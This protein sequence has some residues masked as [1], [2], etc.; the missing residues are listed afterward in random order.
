VNLI[1]N[2][3][4]RVPLW[5]KVQT[6]NR[7]GWRNAAKRLYVQRRILAT[8]SIETS[9]EGPVEVRMLTWHRDW[10]NCLWALKSFYCF[11][12]VQYP[13]YIHDGGLKPENIEQLKDHFPNAVIVAAQEAEEK[14]AAKF[15]AAGWTR[16]LAYRGKNLATRKLFDFFALSR[17]SQIISIDSDILF[18]E[19]PTEL[20]EHFSTGVNLYNRDLQFGYSMSGKELFAAFGLSV[21]PLINSGLSRVEVKSIDFGLI[22]EWLANEKLFANEWVTEQTLHALC[23]TLTGVQLLPDTYAVGIEAG[24]PPKVV[25]KHYPGYFRPLLYQEGMMRLL[26]SGFLEQAFEVSIAT[27]AWPRRVHAHGAAVRQALGRS[28]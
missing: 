17:A 5:V 20:V 25:A 28:K 4:R 12:G 1:R 2:L 6:V 18:F 13:L 26:K 23:S 27:R 8:P 11:S 19:R 7:E 16:C 24:F 22:E 21:E 10:L 15:K 14:V 9:A 3:L